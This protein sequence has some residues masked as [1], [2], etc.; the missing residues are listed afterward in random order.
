MTNSPLTNPRGD[1]TSSTGTSGGV[2]EKASALASEAG[3][4]GRHVVDVAKG[5]SR[6]VA[7]ETGRQARRFM[8]QVGDELSSQASTQQSRIAEGLR[9][10]GSEFSGMAGDGS[11]SGFAVDLV[12]GAGERADAA[13]RWLDDRDPGSLVEEVK[14]FARRRPGVF[15]AIAVG[16]GVVAGRLTRAIATPSEDSGSS[17]GSSAEGR[18][19]V[20]SARTGTDGFSAPPVPPVTEVPQ[21]GVTTVGTAGGGLGATG[22]ARPVTPDPSG[23]PTGAGGV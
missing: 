4:A 20:S 13:A 23:L 11:R 10:V 14:R 9:S 8:G 22:T 15:I 3:D 18:R 12:R 21:T 5:E 1:A 7:S 17:T 6:G 19:P 2:G 16:A